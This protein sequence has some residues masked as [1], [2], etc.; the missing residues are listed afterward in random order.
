MMVVLLEAQEMVDVTVV[1]WI[2][3][4]VETVV[5]ETAEIFSKFL[6]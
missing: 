1:E 4:D 3:V 6:S 5:K 2:A